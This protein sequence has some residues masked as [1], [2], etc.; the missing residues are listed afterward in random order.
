MSHSILPPDTPE[1]SCTVI[2]LYSYHMSIAY[3]NGAVAIE[4]LVSPEVAQAC[5]R[6]ELVASEAMSIDAANDAEA[7]THTPRAQ[8]IATMT[9]SKVEGSSTSY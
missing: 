3:Q 6:L 8:V 4:G 5:R 1:P 2:V 7:H 9:N